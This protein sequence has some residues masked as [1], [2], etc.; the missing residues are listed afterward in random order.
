MSD[1]TDRLE[2]TVAHQ[3]LAIEEL[4]EELR[5]QGDLIDRLRTEMLHAREQMARV[6]DAL[7]GPIEREKP[8]HY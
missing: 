3:A 7:D 8:P 5:R 6:E 1:R 2:E 4:S